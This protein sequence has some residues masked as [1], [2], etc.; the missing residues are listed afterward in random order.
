MNIKPEQ[1]HTSRAPTSCLNNP[2]HR[3]RDY[4]KELDKFAQF[5]IKIACIAVY[6]KSI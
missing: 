2:D 4:G 1:I 3:A 6:E 5:F